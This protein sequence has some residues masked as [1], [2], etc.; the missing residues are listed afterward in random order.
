MEIKKDI[1]K[2]FLPILF[3]NCQKE[4]NNFIESENK[5]NLTNELKEKLI[6][7]LKGL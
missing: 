3:N 7:I 1:S 2:K 5:G 6:N 4:M